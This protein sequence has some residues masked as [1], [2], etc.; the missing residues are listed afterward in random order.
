[1]DPQVTIQYVG[2]EIF[3]RS[4][5]VVDSLKMTRACFTKRRSLFV[6]VEV[7]KALALVMKARDRRK[8]SQSAHRFADEHSERTERA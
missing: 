2:S 3:R 6:E 5:L 1:M 4:R 8:P 7:N